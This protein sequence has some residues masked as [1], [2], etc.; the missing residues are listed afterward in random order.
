MTPLP[1]STYLVLA[2]RWSNSCSKNNTHSG[3]RDNG[4]TSRSN[5]EVRREAKGSSPSS[6]TCSF[7]SGQTRTLMIG[8]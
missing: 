4:K 6:P 2:T 3:Q 1:T 5:T 8:C 7:H